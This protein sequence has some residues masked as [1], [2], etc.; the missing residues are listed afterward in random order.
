MF[1]FTLVVR[2]GIP[3]FYDYE[4]VRDN[5]T[6][7]PFGALCVCVCVC[8]CVSTLQNLHIRANAKLFVVVIWLPGCSSA[9]GHS[10][11]AVHALNVVA[12]SA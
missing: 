3:I 4:C 7:P 11:C 1:L 2:L 9:I 6:D 12:V 10:E 5:N 8:V